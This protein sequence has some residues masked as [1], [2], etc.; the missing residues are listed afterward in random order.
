MSQETI[1]ANTEVSF[2]DFLFK[3][4]RNRTILWIAAAAIVI[5]FAVFKYFYPFASF[6]HGDSFAYIEAAQQN[7]DVNTYLVGYSRFLRLFSV[8]TTS[9]TILT[10][11]QYIF[12]Q[13]SSIL[14]L[15]TIF[16]FY[17]PSKPVQ[18]ILL[19][20]MV[21]NPLLLHLSNLVSSDCIFTGLSLIWFTSLLW[22]IHK[23]NNKVIILHSTSLFF[24]FTFRYNAMIYPI[25][26]IAAFY[27][28]NISKKRK[29]YSL[30]FSWML[31]GLFVL[32][33]SYHFKLITGYWQYSPFSGWQLTNNAMYAYR[34]VDSADRKPVKN[35]FKML[36]NMIR[37]Y[38]DSTRDIKKH[39]QESLIAST[40]YMWDP[41]FTLYKYRDSLFT[42]DSTATELKKWSSMGPFYKSYGINII[43]KYPIHFAKHFL[44]PNANKYYAP[45]VEFLAF[46]NSGRDS[47]TNKGKDWFRYQSRHIY[48]RTKQ[49]AIHILDFYPILSGVI[50]VVM[51]FGLISLL[52]LN[53]FKERNLIN[54]GI[55]IATIIW[56]LN[57]GFT[58]FASS[59]ALRFQSFPILLTTTFVCLII[60]WLWKIASE[61]GLKNKIATETITYAASNIS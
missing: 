26:S 56:L 16:Y 58:I 24:A 8:F 6:I 37:E 18:I 54:K 52:L 13:A 9:D 50:N 55:L 10:A 38:F 39:P 27:L 11:F 60:G 14:M 31:C 59:A 32:Y 23:P 61:E 41:R 19:V 1:I 5:Q 45:P 22:I 47:V 53:S 49:K 2:K 3:N 15:F 57:A 34:Y 48:T 12:I 20:F 25:I 7:M 33:T 36:D 28:S 40:V 4:K 17:N 46:F 30:A 43:K 35:K 42:K 44:W 21:C 51:L 29:I